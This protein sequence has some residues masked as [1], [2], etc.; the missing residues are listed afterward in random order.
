MLRGL[1]VLLALGS[2]VCLVLVCACENDSDTDNLDSSDTDTTLTPPTN[3]GALYI[4]PTSAAV[5]TNAGD[6]MSFKAGGGTSPYTFTLSD[7]NLG[8]L[9]SQATNPD[10]SSTIKYTTKAGTGVNTITVTDGSA[11]TKQATVTH[12]P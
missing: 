2:V 7:G 10:G 9:G 1:T 4:L 5:G 11:V 12:S 6:S 8:S 3:S